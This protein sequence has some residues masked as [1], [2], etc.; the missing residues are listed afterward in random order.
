MV[1]LK[2]KQFS[3]LLNFVNSIILLI[4]QFRIFD[5]FPNSSV[6]ANWEIG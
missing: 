6:I 5:N 2:K 4:E 3:K 1:K